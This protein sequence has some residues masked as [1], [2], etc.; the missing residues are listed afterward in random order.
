MTDEEG[1][2]CCDYF[3]VADFEDFIDIAQAASK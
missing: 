2:D 1:L 3:T